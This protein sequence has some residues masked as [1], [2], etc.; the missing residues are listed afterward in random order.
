MT[1]RIA[2]SNYG[3]KVIG[4]ANAS[5][6][7]RVYRLHGQ[8][9][10]QIN[11]SRARL[12]L[13][14]QQ[15][16]QFKPNL[17]AAMVFTAQSPGDYRIE[18]KRN[19]INDDAQNI[20]TPSDFQVAPEFEGIV[21]HKPEF[22][23]EKPSDDDLR[24]TQVQLG[25]DAYPGVST[26]RL[27]ITRTNGTVEDL[28]V[29]A[30]NFS[31]LRE[32]ISDKERKYVVS[33]PLPGGWLV[34]SRQDDIIFDFTPPHPVTPANNTA[35]TEND[36]LWDGRGVLFTWQKTGISEGYIL[37]VS[38]DPSFSRLVVNRR[39][40]DNF[41]VFKPASRDV[42]YYWRVRAFAK[43]QVSAPS[44]AFQFS[45]KRTKPAKKKL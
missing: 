23:S 27:Q 30:P 3:H 17:S 7:V 2:L 4:M 5:A 12:V 25:W 41:L 37:E 31:I 36:N 45:V 35:L 29:P 44:E 40:K 19:D 11:A 21:L 33:A 34:K 39:Q 26:Y 42:T 16:A 1:I 43:D 38:E 18:V 24:R 10:G 22:K 14:A 8:A 13:V 20:V 9:S 28:Q 32:N 15:P 6:I